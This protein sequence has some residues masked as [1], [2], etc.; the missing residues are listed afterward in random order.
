MPNG[1]PNKEVGREKDMKRADLARAKVLVIG[2]GVTGTSVAA[3]LHGLG[4]EI[5]LFD[6]REA[7]FADQRFISFER[8]IAENWELAVVSPGWREGHPLIGALKN[9]GVKLISE[10]DL[11][12]LLR[13]EL[14]PSQMWLAVTGTNGKTTTVELAA[15]ML[16]SGGLRAKACGNVGETVIEAVVNG[17]GLD[18]LVLELSSFQLQ[19]SELP[20]FRSVAIL[21]ISDDHVDWHGS[22]ES[23][24]TAKLRILLH[25]ELAI[26][27]G[28]DSRVVGATEMWPGCKVFFSLS[29][30]KPGELGV[31]E[32]LLVDRFFV[33]DPNEAQMIAQI[34][35]IRP[36]APHSISNTL[37]AAGLARSIGVS[38]QMIR[39]AVQNFLPGRHR[40]ETV[41]ESNGV[42]WVNDSKATN[43]H[44]AAASL[45]SFPS[46]IWIAGG[47]AKGASMTELAKHSKD[48]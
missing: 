16:R 42:T 19:W 46:I 18:Y 25:A 48:H 11:A 20:Q 4:A 23:Y 6:E 47:L 13:S 32:D 12:W 36:R 39:E 31:V 1:S 45:A 33:A 5:R 41:F 26:L 21:N 9:R 43:P 28:D 17:E 22:L 34:D 37:A 24:T 44:A 35:E 15:A 30:P 29:P 8:A 40:I 10:V 3:V 27:N 2:A 38:H 14:R 7:F